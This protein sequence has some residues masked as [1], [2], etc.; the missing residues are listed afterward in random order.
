M[1]KSVRD[2]AARKSVRTRS[3]PTTDYAHGATTG[4]MVRATATRP[5]A[6]SVRLRLDDAAGDAPAGV[7]GGLRLEVVGVAVDHERLA[8]DIVITGAEEMTVR[9][10]LELVFT[11]ATL[12]TITE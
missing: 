5:K 9:R 11:P 2:R 1:R 6:T 4:S 12:L 8:D 10:A 3:G 7:A